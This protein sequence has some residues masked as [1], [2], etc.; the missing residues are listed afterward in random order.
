MSYSENEHVTYWDKTGCVFKVGI[1][2]QDNFSALLGMYEA[3]H[4][5]AKAQGLPPSSP[6]KLHRWVMS[7]LETGMNLLVWADDKVV[8]HACL[9]PN[10]QTKEA[11]YLIFV[12]RPFQHRGMGSRLTELAL[13]KARELD[14]KMIWLTVETFN[15]KAIRLYKKFGFVFC[16]QGGAER[17]M[18]LEL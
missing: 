16:D 18:I 17:T 14:L 2:T 15:F 11:E 3:F 8:A 4:P 12:R 9:F 1:G 10:S 5:E 13:A 6:E 7:C